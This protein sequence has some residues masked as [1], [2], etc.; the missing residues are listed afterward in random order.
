[1]KKFAQKPYHAMSQDSILSHLQSSRKGLSDFDASGRLSAFG[2]NALP[3]QK[4]LSQIRL[5]LRQFNNP[6]IFIVIFAAII[7]FTIDHVLDASF[8]MF[9]VLLN[10]VVG[11][12]QENKAEKS[13]EKL[14][15]TIE[16]Y[17]RVIRSGNKKKILAQDLVVGDVVDLMS[18]DRV[19]ADGRL[20][21]VTDLRI[22]EA[23]LTGEWKDVKKTVEEKE[24][25]L[26]M[27]DQD[28]MVFS[29]TSVVQGHGIM[30]V[31][32]TG[33]D[34][35]IGKISNFV[36]ESEEPQ[37]PLQKKFAH[38]SKII[39]AA[40]F[41]SIILFSI[42]GILRGESVQDIFV[43]STALVVSAIPE[44][45][46]PA[47]TVVLI[48]GMR[49][50]SR[51]RALVRKLNASE[52]MGAITTICSDKTGTLT[53][54]EMRVSNV[55]T[56]N[57]LLEDFQEYGQIGY[58]KNID[59][60]EN[61][62]ALTIASVVNDAYIE[63]KDNELAKSV[64]HGRPT[65][66][67]LL[68]AGI[69]IGVDPDKFRMK[70]KLIHEELFRSEKKYAIRVHEIEDGKVRIMMLGAPEQMFK[71]IT[72]IDIN[73]VKVL[74][75]EQGKQGL[76]NTFEK[77]TKKGL[78][79]LACGEKVL[80]K[81]KYDKLDKAKMYEDMTIVGYVA[82][83][84]PLRDDVEESLNRAEIAGIKLV[85][86]TGDHATTV[87]SI[88][89]E[90]GHRVNKQD[91]CIGKELD[92]IDDEEI[93]EKVKNTKIFARVLPE[94]KIRIVRALQ[95][96]GEV[97]AM[98]GDGIND[99]PAIKASDVGISIGDGT[100]IAKEVS[101]IVLLDG[102]FSTIVK[103]IEQGR[104]I[105]ENIRRILIY[106]IAD[107]F[108]ELFLFFVAMFFGWP[109]PLLPLQILWINLIE[110]SF[111]NIALTTEYDKKGLMHEPPRNPKDP[112]ITKAYKKFM[113]I[114]FIVSGS[115]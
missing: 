27:S 101:D 103:A 67:A 63:N 11:F 59:L 56:G 33:I 111:P 86:I 15:G 84:D 6:L 58:K 92:D 77:I 105:Y 37:T 73:D 61:V 14:R 89:A 87:A 47:I 38:L 113:I 18:G 109:L 9:V 19:T 90:L 100:D 10:A 28:N 98:V 106:L 88:M 4:K 7:S 29:G 70:H 51:Q 3:E 22:N 74:L 79:V 82:L 75:D 55:I 115:S 50:L 52:T 93:K 39:G 24:E 49:R 69:E 99:A 46:I 76:E 35:E 16:Q 60:V 83:K 30:V 78:R 68:M 85:V 57:N 102:S 44:G 96:N 45:L 107:D 26:I 21:E 1:M 40:V 65:D 34:T 81:E 12:V 23:A 41:I 91:I 108:S 104:V 36:K 71:R 32:A 20:I 54:G 31:T 66:K 53:E 25:D 80:T 72:H 62:K 42:L 110:D 94:H 48:F 17:A 2:K 8:I 5:F 13:L 114:V 95:Q 97:V 64:V 112:I 43:A